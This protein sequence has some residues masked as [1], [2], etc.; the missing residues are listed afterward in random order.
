MIDAFNKSNRELVLLLTKETPAA[1]YTLTEVTSMVEALTSELD[2]LG[3]VL[4]TL[5]L[6]Q[7]EKCDAQIDE[8]DNRLNDMKNST[9]ELQTT[10]F[11]AVE[12][13]EDDLFQ[14]TAALITD[15]MGRLAREELAEDYLDDEAMTL[16]M[17]RE[18][19]MGVLGL[20]HDMHIGRLLKMEDQA[21]NQET[22]TYTVCRPCV[23]VC[24]C[25]CVSCHVMYVMY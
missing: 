9:L 24:V 20:S 19:C 8:F 7:V 15:L 5:E 1:A 16:L 13:M 25:V 18:S 2:E 10:V 14:D 3:D 17:D 6:R 23:R 22:K 11:R 4:M 12:K 21:R